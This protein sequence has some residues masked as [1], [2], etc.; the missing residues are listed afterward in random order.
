MNYIQ[1]LASKIKSEL[2]AEQIPENSEQLFNMYAVLALVKGSEVT[3]KDV[4]NAWCAWIS[5]VNPSHESAIPFEHLSKSVQ[6]MDEPYTEAIRK[7]AA[8]LRQ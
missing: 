4:H 5:S 6:D 7:A 3:N 1:Q 8:S 2:A